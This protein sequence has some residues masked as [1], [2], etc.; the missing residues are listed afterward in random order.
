MRAA[1]G[2][3]L[4]AGLLQIA[5][6]LLR[7]P[8]LQG[9]GAATGASPAPKVF[10]SI[11]GMEPFSTRF[12][13]EWKDR[14]GV[15]HE[16]Q[17]TPAIYQRLAGPYNRRNVYGAVLAAGPVMATDARLVEMY[18]SVT[19]YALCGR[20][21]LLRELGVDPEEVEGPVRLRYEPLSGRT[22]GGLPRILQVQCERHV[23]DYIEPSTPDQAGKS[24]LAGI[25]SVFYG[26]GWKVRAPI[27]LPPNND[28]KERRQRLRFSLG[29]NFELKMLPAGTM[30]HLSRVL[31]AQCQ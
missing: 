1:V 23:A 5:G 20:A 19:R 16:L 12:F 3:L 29:S 27:Q 14:Q 24:R 6:D 15:A 25:A 13:L 31:H 26:E 2:A 18:R 28:S 7:V 4:I 22:M 21:P 11:R 17:L 10:T 9:I 30:N 8:A